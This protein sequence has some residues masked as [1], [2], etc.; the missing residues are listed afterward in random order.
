MAVNNR[1]QEKRDRRREDALRPNPSLGYGQDKMGVY[2]LKKRAFKMAEEQLRRAVWLN[3]YEPLFMS[4]LAICLYE[5]GRIDECKE[6]VVKVLKAGR[7][8]AVEDLVAYLEW[9]RL[10]PG[11]GHLERGK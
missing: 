8:D 2:F 1:K 9:P 6:L 5:T 3:P 4:H 10:K 11:A 7:L